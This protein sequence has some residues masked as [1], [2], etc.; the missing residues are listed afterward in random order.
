MILGSYSIR[1]RVSL[2]VPQKKDE[3][4][5]FNIALRNFKSVLPCLHIK[6]KKAPTDQILSQC[7]SSFFH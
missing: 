5:N 4:L 7:S 6:L 3:L 1:G 2:G